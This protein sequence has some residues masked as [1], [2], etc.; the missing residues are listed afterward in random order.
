MVLRIL[1]GK[2][3]RIHFVGIGGVGMA[4]LAH[5]LR[6]AGFEVSGSDSIRS[7]MTE[8]L[9][10]EGIEVRIGHAADAVCPEHLC[11]IRTPA[12]DDANPELDRARRLG[13]PVVT[14][15]VV[16][17]A[18]LESS[19]CIA[20]CGTHGKTTTGAMIAHVLGRAGVSGSYC[21]GGE[22]LTLDGVAA[23]G[24]E[25]IVVEADESDGTL[26]NYHPS[27]GVITN[28][29][30]DHMEHFDSEDAFAACFGRF[31]GQT[32]NCLV[33]RG[34]DGRAAEAASQARI[35]RSFGMDRTFDFWGEIMERNGFSRRFLLGFP[36]GGTTE[37]TLPLPGDYNVLN[38][39][40]AAAAARE[41]GV[42]TAEIA[43]GLASFRGVRRRFERVPDTGN[44]VVI[45]DYAHH[46]TEVRAVI[47]AAMHLD[48]RRLVAVFQPHRYTRTLAMLRQ[49]PLSFEGVDDLTIVPV[50][51]ASEA[52]LKGA[53]SK[54]LAA[55]FTESGFPSPALAG[56]LEEA[57]ARMQKQIQPGDLLLVLGAGD[58]EK[59]ASWAE[60][61]YAAD[62]GQAG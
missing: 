55:A 35:R 26:Q 24:G 47:R 30:F 5:H 62:S 29:E 10:A 54:D 16:L 31:A 23:T 43:E 57:W 45:S 6:A 36:G 51:A 58:V 15:G 59:I 22:A 61:F 27:I 38:A 3:G 49:F 19:E 53:A 21:I 56:S 52:P 44:V 37:V 42:S 13:K 60:L 25:P 32:R 48:Y 39:V 46:P 33:Y 12:V 28:I 9:C 7:R 18:Y 20:V 1:Q 11:V 2:P 14:R 40:A 50:Y 8:W 4:G 17:P 34:D 41:Q